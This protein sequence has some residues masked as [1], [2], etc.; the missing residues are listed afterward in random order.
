MLVDLQYPSGFTYSVNQVNF[1]GH[2][3]LDNGVSATHKTTFYYQGEENQ[4]SAQL[5]LAGPK[6]TDYT[7]ATAVASTVWAPCGEVRALNINNQVRL[8][9]A[10]NPSGSG[11]VRQWLADGKFSQVFNFSWKNC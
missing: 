2:A 7:V 3:T 5:D 9:N 4:A 10:G 8:S 11:V 6:D 1:R